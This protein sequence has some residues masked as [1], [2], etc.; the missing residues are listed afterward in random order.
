M[1][2]YVKETQQ[3]TLAFESVAAPGK[4]IYMKIGKKENEEIVTDFSVFLLV[5][6]IALPL[7]MIH[8]LAEKKPAYDISDGHTHVHT[9]NVTTVL[10]QMGVWLIS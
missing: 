10:Y 5:S 1:D 3:G 9:S 8:V 6:D 7:W 2:F 4:Y